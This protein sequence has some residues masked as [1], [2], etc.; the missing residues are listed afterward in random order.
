LY[1]SIAAINPRR[2][3]L[4]P[5][6]RASQLAPPNE[7]SAVPAIRPTI[8]AA[9]ASSDTPNSNRAAIGGDSS[10]IT[11]IG[12]STNAVTISSVVA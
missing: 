3:R 9:G 4:G 10:S 1:S 5:S 6:S 12:V 8:N 2:A 11:P 7:S